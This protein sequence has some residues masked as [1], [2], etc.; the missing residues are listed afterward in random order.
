MLYGLAFGDEVSTRGAILG[1]GGGRRA[2]R[3]REQRCGIG[4]RCALVRQG[5]MWGN[6]DL[7]KDWRNT[8]A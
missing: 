4:E 7:E 6:V 2:V 1:G 8:N 5:G 3:A